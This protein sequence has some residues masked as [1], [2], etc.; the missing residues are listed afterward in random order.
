[1]PIPLIIPI[2]AAVIGGV[3]AGAAAGNKKPAA[4]RPTIN[5]FM[6]YQPEPTTT[7]AEQAPKQGLTDQQKKIAGIV[8]LAILGFVIYKYIV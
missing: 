7:E 4:P 5:T 3:A 8:I 1:M 6:Q 2:G